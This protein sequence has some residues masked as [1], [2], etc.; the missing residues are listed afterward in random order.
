MLFDVGWRCNFRHWLILVGRQHLSSRFLDQSGSKCTFLVGRLNIFKYRMMI[1]WFRWWIMLE[2]LDFWKITGAGIL[3]MQKGSKNG[4]FNWNLA[5]RIPWV[6][7]DHGDF[8]PFGR[9]FLAVFLSFLFLFSYLF[10]WHFPSCIWLDSPKE[11]LMRSH[12]NQST[13]FPIF[14]KKLKT[15]VVDLS[16]EAETRSNDVGMT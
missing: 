7:G 3:K 13:K 8:P 4:P 5:T 14:W 16:S 6:T 2:K 12:A 9:R 1:P 15:F 11:N 10:F